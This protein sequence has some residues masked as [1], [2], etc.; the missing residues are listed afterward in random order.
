MF[1]SVYREKELIDMWISGT[2]HSPN[3]PGKPFVE[4][5]N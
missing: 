5:A 4:I 1:I 2:L 3:G